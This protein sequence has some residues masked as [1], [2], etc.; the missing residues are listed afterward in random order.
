[1]RWEGGAG[2]EVATRVGIRRVAAW[3][4]GVTAVMAGV[5]AALINELHRGWPWWVAAGVVVLVAAALSTWLTLRTAADR[6]GDRL[7]A[8][9]VKAVRDIGGSVETHASGGAPLPGIP[10]AGGDQ[11]GVGA[12]KA[13]R[14]IRGDVRTTA[15]LEPRQ[16]PHP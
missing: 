10:S 14:D 1:M 2:E 3:G 15:S 9:A 8:A 6:G 5:S 16:R 13:G 12:V 7:G 11:L 4:A